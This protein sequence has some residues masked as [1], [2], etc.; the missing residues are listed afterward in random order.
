[1]TVETSGQIEIGRPAPGFTLKDQH[2][3]EISLSD[4]A[5]SKSVALIFYPFAFTGICRGEL[6]EIRDNLRSFEADNVQVLAV[7]VDSIFTLRTFADVEGYV[8]PLLSDF[9]PHGEVARKY[10]VF[11]ETNG[12]AR[13]GTFLIDTAGVVRW[14]VINP[15][16]QARSLLDYRE[17]I[18]AL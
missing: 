7:S 1:M 8:F 2:G 6:C 3:Q 12:A 4:F 17:A 16:G 11:N 5:G 14:K 10:G 9:W 18:A 13:R 15:S